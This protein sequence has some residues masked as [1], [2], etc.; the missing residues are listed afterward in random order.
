M[1][2]PLG[3]QELSKFLS[4]FNRKT[5][6]DHQ[7]RD[8]FRLLQFNCNRLLGQQSK[9]KNTIPRLCKCIVESCVPRI[10][11]LMA[12]YLRKG[13]HTLYYCSLLIHFCALI[14]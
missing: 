7:N 6:I 11:N 9:A 1:K 12:V 4:R 14:I 5:I 3:V 2:K 13:T 10:N 8:R